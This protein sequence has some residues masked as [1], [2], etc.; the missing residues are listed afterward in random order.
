MAESR[1]RML[2]CIG[3]GKQFDEEGWDPMGGDCPIVQ[4]EDGVYVTPKGE[5]ATLE[6]FLQA[7]PDWDERNYADV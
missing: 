2:K 3:C 7:Y 4:D 6:L 1:A 5:F